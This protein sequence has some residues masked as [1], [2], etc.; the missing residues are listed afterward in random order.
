MVGLSV[1]VPML[2]TGGCATE[3]ETGFT[4]NAGPAAAGER[5]EGQPHFHT[6]LVSIDIIQC[7]KKKKS[8]TK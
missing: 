8:I 4:D 2:E 5:Q 6:R 3:S 7:I 1:K